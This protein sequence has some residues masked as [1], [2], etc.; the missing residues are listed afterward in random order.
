MYDPELNS[1]GCWF[2]APYAG[3]NGEQSD[4]S[5]IGPFI[6]DG[7]NA[8]LIWSGAAMF[9]SNVADFRISNV[10]GEPLI[11]LFANNGINVLNNDF[12]MRMHLN[13][14]EEGRL[15]THEL[16]FDMGYSGECIAD[17]DG[18]HELDVTRDGWPRVYDWSSYNRIGLNES[19]LIP[20]QCKG[21]DY[22]HANAVDKTPEGDYLLSVRHTDTINKLSG[23]D[24]S[25][26]WRLGGAASDFRLDGLV[27][28]RQHDVKWRSRNDTHTLISLLGNAKGED[29]QLP[30]HEFSR[31]LL[32]AI[33]ESSMVATLEA[34]FDHPNS[35]SYAPRRGNYQLLSNRNVFMG[36]SERAMQSEYTPEG[37]L[38]WEA[39]LAIDWMGSYRNYK[40]DFVSKPTEPPIAV[41][42]A[43]GAF[44]PK[45]IVHVSWNGATEVVE[46]RL[47]QTLANGTLSALVATKRKLG[48]ET[49]LSFDGYAAYIVVEAVNV[50]GNAI[51]NTSI[52]R[53][54]AEPGIP[55][56]IIEEGD[57]WIPPVED[58]E[59]VG[60]QSKWTLGGY[61]AFSCAALA[62]GIV[63]LLG[64]HLRRKGR[65]IRRALSWRRSLYLSI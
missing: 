30:T 17:F 58:A 8:E 14:E 54:V 64:R 34:H 43:I 32:V 27:F 15:N 37:K 7:R 13:P 4:Q 21:W 40:H 1:P 6:Y 44:S 41:S 52:V 19:T 60:T 38:I 39:V 5:W 51:R 48:F 53:T 10:N 23:Q 56:T 20:A 42:R 35:H 59:V 63:T 22:M 50:H 28:S 26:L 47:F 46:W 9:N 24:G 65:V 31:G 3:L 61:F 55:A 57:Q 25:I 18:F 16:S 29:L 36:W 49:K 45:T 12:T 33:D 62:C 11:T 2:V